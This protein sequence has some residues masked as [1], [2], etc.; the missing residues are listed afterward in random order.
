MESEHGETAIQNNNIPEDEAEQLCVKVS[1]TLSNAK[2]IS[3]NR[4]EK[5]PQLH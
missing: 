5:K 1:T 2:L 3:A 4:R